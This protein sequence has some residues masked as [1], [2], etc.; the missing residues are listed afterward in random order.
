MKPDPLQ[1]EIS[2][3]TALWA[4]PDTMPNPVSCVAPTF[5]AV[6][7]IFEGSA[8]ASPALVGA[9]PTGIFSCWKSVNARPTRCGRRSLHPMAPVRFHRYAFNYGGQLRGR[10]SA[11]LQSA[12]SRIF[13]PLCVAHSR[14]L[15]DPS[16]LPIENRRYSRLKTCA[17]GKR[18]AYVDAFQ[19]RLERGRWFYTPCLGWRPSPALFAGEGGRRLG[20]GR[21]WHNQ[22]TNS[23]CAVPDYVGP[24]AGPKPLCGGE[25]WFRDGSAPCATENHV[26]PMR[27]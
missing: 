19:R 25:G 3:P 20:D 22:R 6:K 15:G 24:P 2:G 16:V 17:T 5:S 14:A 23:S 10:C 1:L 9:S 11:D 8:G 26:I 7:G 12:V 13:N 27:N 18:R 21:R 4:R